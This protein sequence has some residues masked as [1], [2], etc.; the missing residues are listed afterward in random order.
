MILIFKRGLVTY[1][2]L[3]KNHCCA[4]TVEVSIFGMNEFDN[5]NNAGDI[6]KSLC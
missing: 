2:L 6:N 4:Q 1:G 3:F 5:T